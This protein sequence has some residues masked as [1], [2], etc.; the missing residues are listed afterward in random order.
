MRPKKL[1]GKTDSHCAIG[2]ARVRS[3]DYCVQRRS[4]GQVESIKRAKR[5]LHLTQPTHSQTVLLRRKMV[6]YKP[7]GLDMRAKL[8]EDPQGILPNE[9]AVTNLSSHRRVQLDLSQLANS[10]IGGRRS[11]LSTGALDGS[12][13]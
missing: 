7:P 11:F 13:Q 9:S 2:Q 5:P 12:G 3:N 1:R 6:A 8:C 4:H 10:Q